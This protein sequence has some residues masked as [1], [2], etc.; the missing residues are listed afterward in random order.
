M[1]QFESPGIEDLTR[2]AMR[3]VASTPGMR[4]CTTTAKGT[5]W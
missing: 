5:P 4:H 2:F 1:V 3:C